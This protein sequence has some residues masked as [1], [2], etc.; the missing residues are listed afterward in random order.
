MMGIGPAFA[1]ADL[2]F[3]DTFKAV[4]SSIRG[5]WNGRAGSRPLRAWASATDWNTFATATGTVA[6]PDGGSLAFEVDQGPAFR[7]TYGVGAQYG[8]TRWFEMAA[9][10]G[11]DGHGG[12]YLA[13]V[14]VLRF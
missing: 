12:W 6:D 2:G 5:G 11:I 3:D 8:A 7:Y 14:P 13:L 1:Q 9:D 10:A 4:V